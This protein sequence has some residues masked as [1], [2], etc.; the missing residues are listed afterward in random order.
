MSGTSMA[1]PLV[2]GAVACILAADLTKKCT[3][4]ALVSKLTNPIVPINQGRSGVPNRPLLHMPPDS[5]AK[6]P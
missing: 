6:C 1:T 4:D 5:T 2:A 3:N